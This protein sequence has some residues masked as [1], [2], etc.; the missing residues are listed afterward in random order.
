MV[1][2]AGSLPF[3]GWYR[4]YGC[5]E[6]PESDLAEM[7]LRQARGECFR[8]MRPQFD[9]STKRPHRHGSCLYHD[10]VPPSSDLFAGIEAKRYNAAAKAWRS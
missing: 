9:K 7:L 8:C 2:V 1:A 10:N 4:Q 6:D 5:V 3:G